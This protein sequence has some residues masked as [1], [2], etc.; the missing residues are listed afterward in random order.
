MPCDL[1]VPQGHLQARAAAGYDEPFEY[2][3]GR[4]LGAL[5]PYESTDDL[6]EN[7]QTKPTTKK[8]PQRL[9]AL[10]ALLFSYAR[11]GEFN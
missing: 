10:S 11:K 1:Q 9:L 7:K 4:V 3:L 5:S 2:L 6:K 8:K